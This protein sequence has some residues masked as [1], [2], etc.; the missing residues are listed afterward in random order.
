MPCS[1]EDKIDTIIF[2]NGDCDLNCYDCPL[3]LL[4]DTIQNSVSI[5][6]SNILILRLA[7]KIKA[8]DY[9]IDIPSILFDEML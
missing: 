4:C 5:I 2:W 3:T 8:N 7:Y 6:L 9:V 1:T